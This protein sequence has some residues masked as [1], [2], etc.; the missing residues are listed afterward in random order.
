[1]NEKISMPEKMARSLSENPAAMQ[2][3]NSLSTTDKIRYISFYKE[4][5]ALPTENYTLKN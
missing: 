5:Y 4:N 1:M 2:Y 3:F